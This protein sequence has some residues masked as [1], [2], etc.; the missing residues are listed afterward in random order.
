MPTKQEGFALLVLLSD[1]LLHLTIHSTLDCWMFLPTASSG[2]VPHKREV[3]GSLVICSVLGAVG[4]ES[5]GVMLRKIPRQETQTVH[6]FQ[7]PP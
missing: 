7:L 4:Y 6:G 1:A 5:I 2:L 3:W